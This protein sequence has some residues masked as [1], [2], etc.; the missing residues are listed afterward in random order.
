MVR[1]LRLCATNAEGPVQALARDLDPA[2]RNETQLSYINKYFLKR[3]EETESNK[4]GEDVEKLEPLC[5]AGETIRWGSCCD[6]MV[7]LQKIKE[8]CQM[9][10]QFHFGV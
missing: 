2:C 8:N 6:R 5:M 9:T 4:C 3:A 1:G 10:Q 7:V